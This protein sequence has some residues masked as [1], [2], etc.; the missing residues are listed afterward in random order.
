LNNQV[1]QN[2]ALAKSDT[3][4]SSLTVTGKTILSE[5]G[6]T[7]KLT[8]GLLSFDGLSGSINS[9]GK[10]SFQN[11]F[12]DGVTIDEKGNVKVSGTLTAHKL[13]TEEFKVLGT[14]TA[15]S[16][17]LPAGQKTVFVETEAVNPTSRVLIT[18][19]VLTSYVLAVTEKSEGKFKVEAAEPASTNISFDWFVIQ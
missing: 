7:G 2:L 13:E 10:L 4:L 12:G 14:K 8:V 16:A 11:M 6:I 17:V 18:P 9:L 3:T 15:G 5:T 19:T 1:A